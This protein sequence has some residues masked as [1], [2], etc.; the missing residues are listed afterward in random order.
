MPGPGYSQR[1]DY[2]PTE[3]ELKV[4]RDL[5]SNDFTIPQNFKRTA[6]VFEDSQNF[7]NQ[8][9]ATSMPSQPQ[10]NPQTETFCEKLGIDDPISLIDQESVHHL[11]ATDFLAEEVKNENEIELDSESDEEDQKIESKAVP[12][13]KF[14]YSHTASSARLIKLRKRFSFLTSAQARADSDRQSSVCW[15]CLPRCYWS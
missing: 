9:R 14:S 15:R 12:Y 2:R 6:K 11:R 10:I 1:I 3:D 7:R 5:F 8:L 4:M 13:K